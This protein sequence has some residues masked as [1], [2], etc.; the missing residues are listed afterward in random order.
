MIQILFY[1]PRSVKF[2]RNEFERVESK[3]IKPR[4]A[5]SVTL[6]GGNVVLYHGIGGR[7][8]KSCPPQ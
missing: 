1:G 4:E 7:N 3:S 5:I 8:I 6:S 2:I